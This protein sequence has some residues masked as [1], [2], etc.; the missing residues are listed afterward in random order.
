MNYSI[1]ASVY[2]P[3]KENDDGPVKGFATVVFGNSIKVTNVAILENKATKELFVSMPRYRSN[4]KDENGDPV[5]KDVCNPITRE[6]R[7]ELFENILKAFHRAT[8]GEQAVLTVDAA[9]QEVPDFKV[10]V[11]PY[12][13]DGS[14]IRG[15]ARIY[16]NDSF[17]ISNV[18]VIQGNSGLFVTMPSFK[19]GRL[20]E[21]GKEEYRDVCYPVTKAFREALNKAIIEEYGNRKD[22]SEEDF[23]EYVAQQKVEEMARD[24][25]GGEGRD[26]KKEN[27]GSEGKSDDGYYH[28]D[29]ELPFR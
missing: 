23:A 17:V 21:N 6:F 27:G 3:K 14:Q 18:N 16:V 4:D 8:E 7:T 5:Y 29:G 24:R 19:T 22:R 20:D 11:T 1:R 2:K 10:S 9:D 13:R 25:S 28:P 15:I 12:E 26:G